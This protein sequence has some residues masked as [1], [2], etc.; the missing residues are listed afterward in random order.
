MFNS[1]DTEWWCLVIQ[2]GVGACLYSAPIEPSNF[3][4]IAGL[5]IGLKPKCNVAV[6]RIKLWDNIILFFFL[7]FFYKEWL[8]FFCLCHL[9]SRSSPFCFYFSFHSEYKYWFTCLKHTLIYQP[10]LSFSLRTQQFIV[11][12]DLCML[13]CHM[14]QTTKGAPVKWDTKWLSNKSYLLAFVLCWVPP[15]LM[16]RFFMLICRIIL[17]F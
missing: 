14:G 8:T 2:W 3:L 13:M 9:L 6:W 7:L 4:Q 10:E 12:L 11:R 15:N 16:W 1:C 5:W 17:D